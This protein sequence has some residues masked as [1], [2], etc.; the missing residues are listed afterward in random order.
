MRADG[1]FTAKGAV[2]PA[3]LEYFTAQ[4][5]ML[6]LNAVLNNLDPDTALPEDVDLLRRDKKGDKYILEHEMDLAQ[7][8]LQM[9]MAEREVQ[10]NAGKPQR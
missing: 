8:R 3:E 4:G 9:E 10:V 1:F 2:T 7:G 5:R 6:R